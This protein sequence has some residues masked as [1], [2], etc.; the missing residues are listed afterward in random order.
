MLIGSDY[1]FLEGS[2]PLAAGC[3]GSAVPNGCWPEVRQG[4]SQQELGPL[5]LPVLGSSCGGSW[6]AGWAQ[7]C[8]GAEEDVSHPQEKACRGRGQR[9]K[10]QIVC[11][12]SLRQKTGRMENVTPYRVRRLCNTSAAG[13]AKV[14]SFGGL[15][16]ARTSLDLPGKCVGD[17]LRQAD[18][19][20]GECAVTGT[21]AGRESCPSPAPQKSRECLSTSDGKNILLT[22]Q[23]PGAREEFTSCLCFMEAGP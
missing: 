9:T 17:E 15:L 8:S 21:S 20:P 5:C 22:L 6:L 4:D 11:L 3:D 16:R 1:I 10:I 12:A 7:Q 13:R 2:D 18:S 19:R 23:S 14:Q